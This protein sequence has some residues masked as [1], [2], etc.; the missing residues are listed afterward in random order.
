M[1]PA[2]REKMMI[3]KTK[4]LR[5][6]TSS[7]TLFQTI[8]PYSTVVKKMRLFTMVKYLFTLV[9]FSLISLSS[10]DFK[11]ILETNKTMCSD[12]QI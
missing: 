11:E 3:P 10:I 1:E 12:N 4:T 8:Y 7:K 9:L 6:G 2:E 5:L